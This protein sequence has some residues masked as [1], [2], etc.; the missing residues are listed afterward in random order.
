MPRWERKVLPPNHKDHRRELND[1]IKGSLP[2][3]LSFPKVTAF[4]GN[5]GHG[6]G[7]HYHPRQWELYFGLSGNG[8]MALYEPGRWGED[9]GP[10]SDVFEF[11]KGVWVLIPPGVRH[12]LRFKTDTI[13]QIASTIPEFDPKDLVVESMNIFFK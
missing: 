1:W 3:G 4:W 12:E 7:G 9:N 6:I 13:L 11:E 8:T 10:Q 5:A 2:Q